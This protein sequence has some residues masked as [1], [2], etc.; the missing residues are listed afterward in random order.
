VALG[1]LLLHAEA[2]G[3]EV[4]F[5]ETGHRLAPEFAG[6]FDTLGGEAVLGAPLT[7]PFVDSSTG[8]TIQYTENARLEADPAVQES[9]RLGALGE[10]LRGWRPP[11]EKRVF[12]GGQRFGCRYFDESGHHV[13]GAFLDFLES[14]GGPEVLGYPISEYEESQGAIIQY[15]QRVRLDWSPRTGVRGEVH[16]GPLG[17]MHFAETRFERALLD[18]VL[19]SSLAQYRVLSLKLLPSVRRPVIRPGELQSVALVVRD[20]NGF[21]LNGAAIT[22]VVRS[23]DQER[24]L[25]M[26]LTDVEG[27]TRLDLE[28]GSRLSGETVRLEFQVVFEDL[29][30]I[31]RDFYQVTR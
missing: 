3:Q 27:I 9:S 10:L 8:R 31:T 28:I 15:L 18:P 23:S 1:I 14:H 25:V 2:D 16:L 5:S 29:R 20:Q 12:G 6:L 13:C 30:A 11:V 7:E 4:Y 24:T 22:L 21:A 17:S 19:P 26:P